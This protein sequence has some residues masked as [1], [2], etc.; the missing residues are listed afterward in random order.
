MIIKVELKIKGI[1]GAT[2]VMLFGKSYKSWEQQ[3]QE[4]CRMANNQMSWVVEP[5][6]VWK[7]NAKWI[8]WG[9][10]K[11]CSEEAFQM[12]LN[13]EGCQE[14]DLDNPNPRN[15]SKMIFKEIPLSS[16]PK[17]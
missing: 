2:V 8:G 17:I 14:D 3:Y 15:Y 5:V 6:R 9:G 7:S 10:L 1:K 12:A 4:Y 11:W 13:R 16:L